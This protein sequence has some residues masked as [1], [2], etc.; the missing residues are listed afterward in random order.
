MNSVAGT[1]RTCRPQTT[2]YGEKMASTAA[3]EKH[4]A[5]RERHADRCTCAHRAATDS[6]GAIIKIRSAAARRAVRHA[7]STSQSP[8]LTHPTADRNASPSERADTL[9]SPAGSERRGLRGRHSRLD[10]G[11]LPGA[12]QM[13]A[14]ARQE[15]FSVGQALAPGIIGVPGRC[16]PASKRAPVPASACHRAGAPGD[17]TTQGLKQDWRRRLGQVAAGALPRTP[18]RRA[19]ASQAHTGVGASTLCFRHCRRLPGD[20]PHGHG[21]GPSREESS[22]VRHQVRPL[23]QRRP[24][25]QLLVLRHAACSGSADSTWHFLGKPIDPVTRCTILLPRRTPGRSGGLH[26]GVASFLP[27]RPRH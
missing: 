1:L 9:A 23:F 2:E 24:L 19:G 4:G 25:D 20:S 6:G 27:G 17:R 5:A 15:V 12:L 14:A 21:R 16:M 3:R 11:G 13:W 22:R 8:G 26:W 18:A 7:R 10:L